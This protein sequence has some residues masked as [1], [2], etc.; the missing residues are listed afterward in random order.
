MPESAHKKRARLGAPELYSLSELGMTLLPVFRE[1][2]S[3]GETL[4]KGKCIAP[5]RRI[6][7]RPCS[8][9]ILGIC[10]HDQVLKIAK[11]RPGLALRRPRTQRVFFR[12]TAP[13]PYD[14]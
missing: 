3:F 14:D 2:G 12:S 9:E 8:G 5:I 7:R 1:I 6:S 13:G 10:R 4:K 11:F